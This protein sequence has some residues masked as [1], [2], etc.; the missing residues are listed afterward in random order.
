MPTLPIGWGSI[1]EVGKGSCPPS[2]A[3]RAQTFPLIVP[4]GCVGQ[5]PRKE[6]GPP[7]VSFTWIHVRENLDVL[8][9]VTAGRQRSNRSR[10]LLPPR[11]AGHAS[12][13]CAC[14]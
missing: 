5:A 12:L 14:T 2:P 13:E 9:R 7:F 8:P 11:L 3:S 6:S 1:T 10:M 4:L